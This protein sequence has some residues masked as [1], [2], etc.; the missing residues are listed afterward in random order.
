MLESII[1]QVFVFK[2]IQILSQDWLKIPQYTKNYFEN[3]ATE[4]KKLHWM[5][6]ELESPYHQFSYYDQD[7]EVK[8]AV[9]EASQWF[10]KKM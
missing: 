10:R 2:L 8:E 6:T 1:E 9:T 5:E 4:D 7:A 3:I